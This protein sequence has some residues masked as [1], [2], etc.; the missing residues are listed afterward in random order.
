[1]EILDRHGDRLGALGVYDELQ[2]R[3]RREYSAEPA[4]ETAAL[5]GRIRTH[6]PPRTITSPQIVPPPAPAAVACRPRRRP[7]PGKPA[8]GGAPRCSPRSGSSPWPAS[9][10]GG[11]ARWLRRIRSS[12]RGVIGDRDR[13]LVADLVNQTR[14]SLLASAIGEALRVDLAQSRLVGVL[15]PQQVRGPPWRAWSAA[16]RAR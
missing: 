2:A 8:T 16:I 13:I 1:M 15:S 11:H 9:W 12:R 10:R 14:D 6:S 5:A 4:A 3:F 7:R